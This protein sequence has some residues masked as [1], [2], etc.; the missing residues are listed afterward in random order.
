MLISDKMNARLNE[1]I[2]NEQYSAH[3]YLAM[4][5]VFEKMGLKVFAQ[6]YYKQAGEETEHAMK[7]F[8]Y[9]V[10]TGAEVKLMAIGEPEAKWSDAEE[11]V[12]AALEHELKVTRQINE[13]VALA[14][15]EKDYATRTFL[16]WF[17]D[18]QVE[19]VS[20][21]QEMVDLV[22]MTPKTMILPLE[23]RIYRMLE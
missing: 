15:E 18:E 13:I 5:A 7:I 2:N 21:A 3:I 4:A 9:V 8:K 16:N 17:V 12:R 1:Q 6:Y 10:D 22:T 19:E 11:I 20:S 23:N 14:E